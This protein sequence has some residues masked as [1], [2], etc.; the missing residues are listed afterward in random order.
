MCVRVC[1]DFQFKQLCDRSVQSLATLAPCTSSF[2][3]SFLG[4]LRIFSLSR[5]VLLMC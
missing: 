4:L 3:G 2:C 5:S 1:V